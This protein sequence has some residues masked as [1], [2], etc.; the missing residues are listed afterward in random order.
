M[1]VVTS[2]PTEDELVLSGPVGSPDPALNTDYRYLDIGLPAEIAL[3]KAIGDLD[4]ARRACQDLLASDPEPQLAACLRAEH[5]RMGRL[6]KRYRVTRARALEEIRAEWPD[7]T[8]PMLDE[9]IERKR[10]DVRQIDG[11]QRLLPN[12]LDSLRV[13]PAEV[14]GL[15]KTGD[16]DTRVR[17]AMLEEMRTKGHATR[18]ITVRSSISVPGARSGET[19][20]AWLPI[21]AAAP[22]QSDIEILSMTPG[23]FVAPADAPARTISWCSTNERSFEVVYRYRVDAPYIDTTLPAPRSEMVLAPPPCDDDLIELRPHALFSP[24]LRAL[25]DWVVKG[26]DRPIDRAR[27]IYDHLTTHVDYR[28]QPDYAQLDAIA[29]NCVKSQR[30]DCGV[31]ALAFITMCRIA[32][33]PSR[34]QSGL[35]ASPDHIGPHDWAMF[36]TDEYGW[37]WADVSFGSSARRAG[38]ERRRLHHFGNLDPWRMVANSA[39]QSEFQPPSDAPRWDPFDNQMGE[40]SVD[41]RGCDMDEMLRQVELLDMRGV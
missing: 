5:H 14:P 26:I 16:E 21:P 34:W 19:L 33:I 29:D 30:G 36:H 6:G 11:E 24:Y 25:T 4:A 27:A 1:T 39:Y 12:F 8:E 41:G 28:Y 22:Q 20:R 31:M 35:Y 37:L 15:K 17:D 18:L 7:F 32:G 40:A 2:L 23:G 38:D 13:Y 3:L 9:L 10:I